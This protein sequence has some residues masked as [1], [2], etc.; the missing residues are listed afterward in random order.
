M[1]A[2][3]SMKLSAW[4]GGRQVFTEAEI[5][6]SCVFQ[7][8]KLATLLLKAVRLTT[9]DAAWDAIVAGLPCSRFPGFCTSR[10]FKGSRV[11]V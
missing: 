7:L 9:G 2:P 10:G 5:R 1:R 3:S 6:A 4:H 11:T 8:S